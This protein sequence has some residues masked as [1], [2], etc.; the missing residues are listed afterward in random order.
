MCTQAGNTA[1]LPLPLRKSCGDWGW[2]LG[3]G[4]LGAPEP[5]SE[6][7]LHLSSR[8]Q[9]RTLLGWVSY[10]G[11]GE[12]LVWWRGTTGVEVQQLMLAF[13]FKVHSAQAHA[14]VGEL[15]AT[16]G[17]VLGLREASGAASVLLS[18]SES[19]ETL[20]P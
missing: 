1:E 2:L 5:P 16:F 8:T 13:S 12:Q 7:G 6:L 19:A 18:P 17:T 15:A 4:A 14:M 20:S 10:W 9:Q 11:S 3:P